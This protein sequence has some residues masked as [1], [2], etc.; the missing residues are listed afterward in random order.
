MLAKHDTLISEGKLTANIQNDDLILEIEDD[1]S[2]LNSLEIRISLAEFMQALGRL[3]YR[4]C[5]VKYYL[6]ENIG[7]K[8]EHSYLIFEIPENLYWTKKHKQEL[9]ELANTHCPEGWESDNYFEGQA[10][11]F[12]EGNKFFAKTVMR[13]WV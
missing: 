6:S 12:K 9:I 1:A 8:M 4:P 10:S 2:H 3:A 11:F 5:R 7:K 13:R